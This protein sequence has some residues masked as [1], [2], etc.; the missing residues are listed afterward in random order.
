MKI[1][2]DNITHRDGLLGWILYL[3]VVI[4]LFALLSRKLLICCL[5]NNNRLRLFIFKH[6]K[7]KRI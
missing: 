6:T 1:I 7:L 4:T 2:I 5:R 3:G